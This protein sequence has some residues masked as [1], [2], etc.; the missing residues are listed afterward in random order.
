MKP[1]LISSS[2]FSVPNIVAYIVRK[3]FIVIPCFVLAMAH[4]ERVLYGCDLETVPSLYGKQK[5]M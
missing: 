3:I 1:L 2:L 4:E 5:G